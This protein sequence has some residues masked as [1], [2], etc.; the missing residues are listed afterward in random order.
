MT[1]VGYKI[2]TNNNATEP[3]WIP[4]SGSKDKNAMD[5]TIMYLVE[6]KSGF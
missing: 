6:K 2:R 5:T 4:D 3:F 1:R